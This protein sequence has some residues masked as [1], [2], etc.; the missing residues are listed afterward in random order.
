MMRRY[1]LPSAHNFW[2]KSLAFSVATI[3]TSESMSSIQKPLPP[4]SREKASYVLFFE[5]VDSS[6]LPRVGGKGANLGEL[7][8]AGLPVPPG[9]CVTTEAYVQIAE[10]AD[11]TSLLT[12][13]ASE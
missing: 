8:R 5:E 9:F 3:L 7:T 10:S 4:Q 11:L 12:E 13:L 2:A 1:S 6:Q